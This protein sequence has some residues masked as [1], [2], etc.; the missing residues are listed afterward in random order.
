MRPIYR[1]LIVFAGFA[2]VLAVLAINTAVTRHRL[3]VPDNNQAWVEHTQEILLELSTVEL[4]LKDAESS[5]RGFLYAE[6]PR[7]L[8]S[9]NTAVFQ[10]NGHLNKL[11]E[12]IAD[13]RKEEELMSALLRQVKQ[14]RDELAQ[15]IDLVKARQPKQAKAIVLSDVGRAAMED[16][17]NTVQEM[18]QTEKSLLATRLQQVSA[19]AKRLVITIYGARSLAVVGLILLAYYILREMRHT[20]EVREREEWFRV[21][22]SSIGD[23]VIAT[24]EH[25]AVTFMNKTAEDLIGNQLHE[26]KGRPVQS[27]LPIFHELTRHPLENP[28]AKVL[29]QGR[30][31]GPANH[32][33]LQRSDGKVVPIENSAAPIYDDQRK[34]RGVVMIFRDITGEKQAEEVMRKAEKLAAASRLAASVAHEINNPLE[35]VCNLVYMIKKSEGLSEEQHVYLSMAEHELERVSHVTRQTLGFYRDPT[36]PIPVNMQSVIES[37]LTLYKNKLNDKKI[38]MELVLNPCPPIQGLQGELKQLIANL[39][40]NAADAV[41][42]GG[43][44]R[45]STVPAVRPE[46]SGVEIQVAD[47]GPGIPAENRSHVFEPFFT[48]K[49]DIGTGLGLWVSKEIVERH[50]GNIDVANGGENTLGGAVFTIFMQGVPEAD[51]SAVTPE[52]A[53][54]ERLRPKENTSPSH[55]SPAQN[56]KRVSQSPLQ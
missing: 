54:Q 41:A 51:A 48:T 11:Q 55:T 18:R 47:D 5:Q 31:I 50:R 12:L 38:G 25:G 56:G 53:G 43:K 21:T 36:R 46:G 35:A 33:A 39:V 1:R 22:L 28:V 2:A 45:I 29:E 7:Y 6:D 52:E 17:H 42:L 23:A 14:K 27:V 13:N 15:T 16:I 20:A 26:I 30:T 8:D 24:D 40:A 10:L 37:V 4:L 3:A 9:Y 34:L 44:I 19:S 32:T 49:Q